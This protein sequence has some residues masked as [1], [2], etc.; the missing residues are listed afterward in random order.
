VASAVSPSGTLWSERGRLVSHDLGLSC[1]ALWNDELRFV[2]GATLVDDAAVSIVTVDSSPTDGSR[3]YRVHTSTD[4]GRSFSEG[5]VSLPALPADTVLVDLR[6]E[7][8][9]RGIAQMAQIS[10]AAPTGPT[11]DSAAAAAEARLL[12]SSDAG[13][14]WQL[15]APGSVPFLPLDPRQPS[16]PYVDGH[17]VWYRV[18]ELTPQR[19]LQGSAVVVGVDKGNPVLLRVPG[20]PDS[21]VEL[22]RT[23]GNTLLAGFGA[24]AGQRWYSSADAGRSWTALPG[25][26]G[27]EPEVASGGLWFFDARQG[28]WLR[29][30]GVLLATDDGGRSWQQRAVVGSGSGYAQGLQFTPDGTGWVLAD[31]AIYRST[32]QGRHWQAMAAPAGAVTQLRFAD[33]AT[34]WISTS[35]C[36]F[37]GNI[38]FCQGRLHRT[39]DAGK[40]WTALPAEVNEY[41]PV[42]LLDPL[43]GASVDAGGVVRFTRDGG[44]SW[45]LGK[46]DRAIDLGASALLFDRQGRGWMLPRYD[47]GRLLRSL[48]GGASWQSITLPAAPGMPF[49]AGFSGLSFGDGQ[50]G[51]LVGSA[52]AVL[53][54]DDGGSSWRLQPSGTS[55]SLDQV[56]AVDG[57][58]AWIGGSYPATL[59]TTSTG[60][61]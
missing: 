23:S 26:A 11:S 3:N 15:V 4:G 18:T 5:P 61:K 46:V 19:Q 28:L 44:M 41:T 60:G 56:F 53:A 54:T 27:P 9:G 47:T 37:E 25:A 30:D 20:E 58:T 7:A 32:D 45:S 42:A 49:G 6:L 50:R 2:V 39:T 36:R 33:S 55:R 31:S 21:P 29:S 17:G 14:S 16:N 10:L 48:D 52:G 8:D 40:T 57:R 13:R 22:R 43:R 38:G 1:R 51:W 24:L 35:E 59:L 34:A 12:T